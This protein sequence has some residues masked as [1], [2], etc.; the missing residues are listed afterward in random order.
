MEEIV[1]QA[2]DLA[3]KWHGEQKYGDKPYVAHLDAVYETLMLCGD[4]HHF[5][6][7][8]RLRVEILAYL[9]DILEDT[10]IPEKEIL[11]AFGNDEWILDALRL[12]TGKGSNRKERVAYTNKKLGGIGTRF[13]LAIIVKIADRLSNVTECITTKNYALFN[14][15]KKEYKE[16]KNAVYMARMCDKMWYILDYMLTKNWDWS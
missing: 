15:Y 3:I 8:W 10:R 7:K 14:M 13:E 9:H 6:E 12:V 11:D 1:K 4:I 16:F 5:A 2:R